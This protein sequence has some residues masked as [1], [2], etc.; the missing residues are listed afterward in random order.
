MKPEFSSLG[1]KP[2][3]IETWAIRGGFIDFFQR[4]LKIF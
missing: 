2:K 4:G 1:L 3:S